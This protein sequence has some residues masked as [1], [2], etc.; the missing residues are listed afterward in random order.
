MLKSV[1]LFQPEATMSNTQDYLQKSSD[2]SPI[3][4]LNDSIIFQDTTIITNNQIGINTPS[5]TAKTEIYGSSAV[6]GAATISGVGAKVT[7]SSTDYNNIPVGTLIKADTKTRGIVSKNGSNQ[8]TIDLP[9]Y[10]TQNGIGTVSSSGTTVTFTSDDDYSN[11]LV[12]TQINANGETRSIVSKDGSNHVT[13]N[14]APST[15]WDENWFTYD[16][17]WSGLSF[18]YK[19]PLFKL[20]DEAAKRVLVR[21]DGVFDG[22][23]IT[24]GPWHD[25]RAYGALGDGSNDDTAA[26]QAAI[27]AAWN[28]GTTFL[29]AGTYRISQKLRVVC[30]TLTGANRLT[31]IKAD[32]PAKTGTAVFQKG[33]KYVTVTVQTFGTLGVGDYGN[34]IKATA[35]NFEM[36]GEIVNI[37]G[38]GP[39]TIE[40][41]NPYAGEN[42]TGTYATISPVLEV[43]CDGIRGIASTLTIRN[44]HITSVVQDKEQVGIDVY[45]SLNVNI[46]DVDIEN[47]YVGI[48]LS[49]LDIII[50]HPWILNC[51]TGIHFGSNTN[52]D[53]WSNASSVYG[54]WIGGCTEYGIRFINAYSNSIYSTTVEGMGAET[55]VAGVDFAN[56]S[57]ANSLVGCH[58]ECCHSSLVRI[59]SDGNRIINCALAQGTVATELIHWEPGFGGGTDRNLVLGNGMG[60]V[61]GAELKEAIL[62][63]LAIG[64]PN[65]GAK[66]AVKNDIV[67]GLYEIAV[68]EGNTTVNAFE[69]TGSDKLQTDDFTTTVTTFKNP[70]SQPLQTSGLSMTVTT[71]GGAFA[72][73]AVG[74][75]ITAHD[76]SRIVTGKSSNVEVTVDSPVDWSAG[77]PFD[78]QKPVFSGFQARMRL[79][80]G[81]EKRRITNLTDNFTVTVDSPVDWNNGGSGYTFNYQYPVFAN[82]APGVQLFA[83]SEMRTITAVTDDF[84]VTVDQSW[85]LSGASDFQYKWPLLN[86]CD[87]ATSK[88]LVN[89]D[90]N[91][92][93]GKALPL[94][95][96]DVAAVIHVGRAMYSGTSGLI[97]GESMGNYTGSTPSVTYRVQIEQHPG[98]SIASFGSGPTGYTV[99][100]TTSTGGLEDGDIVKITSVSGYYNGAYPVFQINSATFTIPIAYNG[101]DTGDW[102]RKNDTFKWSDQGGNPPTSW[103]EENVRIIPAIPQLLNNGVYFCIMNKFGHAAGDYW[104]FVTGTDFLVDPLQVSDHGGKSL[105]VVKNDGKT[106][107]GTAEP[108]EKFEINGGNSS[109]IG[110][111]LSGGSSSV[112]AWQVGRAS[113]DATLGV[114]AAATNWAN[115]AAAGDVVLRTESPSQKLFLDTYTG[116]GIVVNNSS[117]GIGTP[118]PSQQ[119]E[120]VGNALL[121][122]TDGWSQVG[123]EA[124]L[125][126]GDTNHYIKAVFGDGV[127]IGTWA[128]PDA[129]TLK[130]DTGRVGIGETNPGS[131]LVVK[132]S[133]DTSGTSSLNVM[134]SGGNS[135]LFVRDDG[136]TGVNTDQPAKKFHLRGEMLI[137]DDDP[138]GW[139]S[140]SVAKL[141]L[142]NTDSYLQNT[143]NSSLELSSDNPVKIE[144]SSPYCNISLMPNGT[145]KVGI[146][147][148]QPATKLEIV[149]DSYTA[150]LRLTHTPDSKYADLQVDGNNNLTITPSSTGRVMVQP[151]NNSADSF[152]VKNT[153]GTPVLNVD[154]VNNRTGVGMNNPGEAL[155][156]NGNIKGS[157]AVI[158]PAIKP[159]TPD[160]TTALQLQTS[161]GTPVLNVDTQNLRVGIG[162][163]SPSSLL[164]LRKDV[165]YD[166]GPILTLNNKGGWGSEAIYMSGYD[167]HSYDPAAAIKAIDM[168]GYSAH[169]T[170]STKVP[171]AM[172]NA[173]TER[174]RIQGDGAVGINNTNPCISNANAK[175][176]VTGDILLSKGADRKIEVPD[177]T[178]G[179]VNGNNLTIEAGNGYGTGNGGNI[180]L[181]PGTKGAS[182]T[183]DGRVGIGVTPTQKL[184]VNGN[185]KG[186]SLIISSA[187]TNPPSNT[188]EGMLW[189]DSTNHILK[190][191]NRA[192]N[193]WNTVYSNP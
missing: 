28:S 64:K 185:I 33:S 74:D 29:P 160:S 112:A 118:N 46:E 57:G 84:T 4:G 56:T 163:T 103:N 121:K 122:G 25:V 184:D 67:T 127:R 34:Y 158:V 106:G 27:D 98:S 141:S 96:L 161:G 171:G 91:M 17:P 191:R 69:I 189:Y 43:M 145:A 128:V 170:F 20:S 180:I 15:A 183:T 81:A 193:N 75:R 186:S 32:I 176:E 108:G 135:K 31:T 86:L 111:I 168:T 138:A 140:G 147:T 131:K 187:S 110:R 9:L 126:L 164:E 72:N 54:G 7:F 148:V 21:A 162:E 71:T 80:A 65:P 117:V 173:L 182:G 77:Y 63:N 123:H 49:R 132:G 47:M 97:D 30:M 152:Q 50:K 10:P 129:I 1:K 6:S 150:Q 41:R 11:V 188:V 113:P 42:I 156:V 99:V 24:K 51:R 125:Y 134:D 23:F 169:I 82:L 136:N 93:V 5:P 190:I 48:Y 83:G 66:L 192:N 87:G 58:I 146:N 52:P 177:Q 37:S 35:H 79:I 59:A 115:D 73:V 101:D 2:G 12:G 94:Y 44:L 14:T 92:A 167:P 70:G 154:T 61:I 60:G 39:W 22:D 151:T 155:E 174:V 104:E 120:V 8:V 13:V 172:S 95:N 102:V 178:S 142:G 109:V 62:S 133:G 68:Q 45:R 53:D 139:Q 181:S 166:I 179:N 85:D 159:P 143:Y 19:N 100:N 105:M 55:A 78:Y 76:E 130:Q 137:E 165:P 26:I 18:T 116:T 3:S 124:R 149:D 40:L 157:G 90:G 16:N 114:A 36:R 144:T 153:A 107:L 89:P 175:L 88:V 38:S 119:L